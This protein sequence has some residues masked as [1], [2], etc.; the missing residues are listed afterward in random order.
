[1]WKVKKELEWRKGEG[2][3]QQVPGV[4]LRHLLDS[5]INLRWGDWMHE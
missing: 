2:K 3:K 5:D 1:M 4:E